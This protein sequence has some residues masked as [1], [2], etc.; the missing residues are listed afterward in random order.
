MAVGRSYCFCCLIIRS[1]NSIF[2][3][4]VGNKILY[5]FTSAVIDKSHN[6][7][8][9]IRNARFIFIQIMRILYIISDSVNNTL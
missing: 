8:I 5:Q 3:I 9:I 1:I 7:L 4:H 6:F 2:Y